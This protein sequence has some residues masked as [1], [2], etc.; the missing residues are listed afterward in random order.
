MTPLHD[1]EAELALVGYLLQHPQELPPIQRLLPAHAL[2][3]HWLRR[4]YEALCRGKQPVLN[5]LQR[6]ALEDGA[7]AGPECARTFAR[8][9][10]GLYEARQRHAEAE[11]R[12]LRQQRRL[13]ALVLDGRPL[14]GAVAGYNAALRGCR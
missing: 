11:A 8:H 2:D 1:H 4:C 13:V 10:L 5:S 6:K 9:L 3:W 14:G 7:A 12:L